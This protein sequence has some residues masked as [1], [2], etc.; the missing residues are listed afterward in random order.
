ML[1]VSL[2]GLEELYDAFR[3]SFIIFHYWDCCR[4][5]T[6][7]QTWAKSNPLSVSLEAQCL[8]SKPTVTST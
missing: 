4:P 2:D 6:H 1:P 5:Y 7:L 8:G 3:G